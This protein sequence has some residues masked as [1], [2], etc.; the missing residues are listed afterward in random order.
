[1]PATFARIWAFTCRHGNEGKPTSGAKDPEHD[2]QAS[3]GE[4]AR[5]LRG[6]APM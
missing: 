3:I 4:L 2:G 5:M 6:S 1:M